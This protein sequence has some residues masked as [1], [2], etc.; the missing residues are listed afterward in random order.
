MLLIC[1]MLLQFCSSSKKMA[2]NDAPPPM[3]PTPPKTAAT[4]FYQRDVMPIMQV[5][6][7]PCHFPEKG[8][9]LPLDSYVAV[10]QN[11][12]AI[13]YRVQL[14]PS[15]SKF[16]PLDSKKPPFTPAQINLLKQWKKEGMSQ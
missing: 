11:I 9:K 5:S 13:L 7:A 3:P 14:S 10:K 2:S 4:V 16:M 8:K 15:E 1:A 12:D 6:C